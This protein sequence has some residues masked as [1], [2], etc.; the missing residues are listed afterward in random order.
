MYSRVRTG[1]RTGDD[2]GEGDIDGE[3]VGA[4]VTVLLI[5]TGA[6]FAGLSWEWTWCIKRIPLSNSNSGTVK[7]SSSRV[8]CSITV[9]SLVLSEVSI[10]MISIFS[11][12]SSRFSVLSLWSSGVLISN[13]KLESGKPEDPALDEIVKGG[14]VCCRVFWFCRLSRFKDFVLLYTLLYVL[15]D[16]ED[17]AG[18]GA[19]VEEV[20]VHGGLVV[21]LPG[22]GV[23]AWSGWEVTDAFGNKVDCADHLGPSLSLTG[24]L[25]GE[26]ATACL[27]SWL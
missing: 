21:V 4:K 18:E 11:S 20:A 19:G 9:I 7:I 6:S 25:R 2:G 22:V 26:G 10:S 24:R 12:F 13:P 17:A 3:G 1:L 5:L 8:I 14:P 27:G 15:T 23:G 16:T